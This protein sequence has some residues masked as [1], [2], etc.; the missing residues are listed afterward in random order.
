MKAKKTF[1][2]NIQKQ[3]SG[4]NFTLGENWDYDKG[5]LDSLLSRKE[6]ESIYLRIPFHVL[7]GELEN[8]NALIEFE[9]PFVINHVVR[10]GLDDT[11]SGVTTVSGLS[12]F[13]HPVDKDGLID[14]EHKWKE[15]GEQ[16]VQQLIAS[17]NLR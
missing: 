7:E 4:L 9:R 15:I 2:G 17:V 16:A 14:D 5:Y 12:Q 3:S 8:P 11:A 1:Y 10:L 6:G 13:Q